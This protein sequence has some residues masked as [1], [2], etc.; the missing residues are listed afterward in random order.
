[1]LRIKSNFSDLQ[2]LE[3]FTFFQIKKYCP[4]L[5]RK[6]IEKWSGSAMSTATEI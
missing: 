5:H 2:N 6:H 4:L 1:M 3:F